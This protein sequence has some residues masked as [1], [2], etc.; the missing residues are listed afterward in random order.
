MYL[1]PLHQG[2]QY[3]CW[4]TVL[5]RVIHYV[6]W[7]MLTSGIIGV[8][9]WTVL[10]QVTFL[11]PHQ[12]QALEQAK[13]LPQWFLPHSLHL[14]LLSLPCCPHLKSRCSLS[15]RFYGYE[16]DE[17]LRSIW[18]WRCFCL[19]DN[20]GRIIMVVMALL[21]SQRQWRRFTRT[22]RS[23]HGLSSVGCRGYRLNSVANLRV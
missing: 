12:K 13:H 22:I 5:T 21:L 14:G 1:L 7:P 19:R 3:P 16:E 23:L 6:Q 8:T 4:R 10:G 18:I 17:S 11:R 2:F 15:D 20:K 9:S